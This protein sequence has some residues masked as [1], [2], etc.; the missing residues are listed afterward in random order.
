[1][2]CYN[3]IMDTL[4]KKIN[5]LERDK[6]GKILY[7][8]LLDCIYDFIV[9]LKKDKKIMQ[10]NHDHNIDKINYFLEKITGVID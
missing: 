10:E 1:M 7:T 9:D 6:Q 2:I 8:D 3:R 5:T 4:L